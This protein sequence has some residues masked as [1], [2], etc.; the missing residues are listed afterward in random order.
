VFIPLAGDYITA[1]VLGGAKGNMAGALVATQFLAAQNWAL[2]S[3]MAVVLIFTILASISIAAVIALV[4][5]AVIRKVRA[6]D[7]ALPA[8]VA[9]PAGAPT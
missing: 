1:S 3:A 5:R 2:G 7:V 9:V 8:T 4:V 6:V